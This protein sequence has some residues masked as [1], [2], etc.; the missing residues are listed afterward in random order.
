MKSFETILK[1]VMLSKAPVS[2]KKPINKAEEYK[3]YIESLK[4]RGYYDQIKG[5]E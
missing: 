4:V 2:A 3:K 1:E 5:E